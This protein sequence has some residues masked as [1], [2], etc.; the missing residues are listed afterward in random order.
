MPFAARLARYLATFILGLTVAF[1]AAAAE[2]LIA[3]YSGKGMRATRPFEVHGQ[4]EARWVGKGRSF[5]YYL[6]R[7]DGKLV[8]IVNQVGPG[9]GSSFFPKPGKYYLDI[10]AS[11]EWKVRIFE[12]D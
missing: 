4:W 10:D 11:G 7:A 2:R 3:E 5:G 6:R 12:L 8:D 1:P 9:P